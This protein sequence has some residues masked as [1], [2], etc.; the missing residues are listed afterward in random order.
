M[1]PPS[2]SLQVTLSPALVAPGVLAA[3]PLRTPPLPPRRG[4]R[5]QVDRRGPGYAAVPSHRFRF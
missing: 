5:Q 4:P 1:N 3:G 2:V